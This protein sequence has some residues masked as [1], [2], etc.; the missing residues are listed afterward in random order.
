MATKSGTRILNASL[1]PVDGVACMESSEGLRVSYYG[2]AAT[3]KLQILADEFTGPRTIGWIRTSSHFE[4]VKRYS[5]GSLLITRTAHFNHFAEEQ[6]L[7][8]NRPSPVTDTQWPFATTKG[9][10]TPE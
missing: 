3:V 10:R 7:E 1:L 5:D 2:A 8:L 6:Y 4:S 9:Q